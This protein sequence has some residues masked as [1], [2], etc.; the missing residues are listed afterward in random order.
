MVIRR[1]VVEQC[2][3]TEALRG[4]DALKFQ[5]LFALLG[6][7]RPCACQVGESERAPECGAPPPL[8]AIE[9]R[10]RFVRR[11]LRAGT[12][13]RL[14]SVWDSS[15]PPTAL[16]FRRE[17]ELVDNNL[18]LACDQDTGGGMVRVTRRLRSV[19]WLPKNVVSRV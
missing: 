10:K 1:Q 16:P 12:D 6:F 4:L 13:V 9:L 8:P 7:D 2:E 3:G 18:L 5:P 11:R 19:G 14:G 17:D 15:C